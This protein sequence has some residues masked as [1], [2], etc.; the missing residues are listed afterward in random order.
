MSA[1]PDTDGATWLPCHRDAYPLALSNSSLSSTE[2]NSTQTVT[3]AM[4]RLVAITSGSRE[5][6]SIA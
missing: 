6:S 4:M 1:P 5:T 3:P 2:E